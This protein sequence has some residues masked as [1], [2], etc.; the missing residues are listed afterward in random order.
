MKFKLHELQQ[1]TVLLQ[2]V[3]PQKV[4][5]LCIK[6]LSKEEVLTHSDIQFISKKNNLKPE[7]IS[8]IYD[9]LVWIWGLNHKFNIDFYISKLEKIPPEFWCVGVTEDDQG[10]K[11]VL[12]HLGLKIGQS[13]KDNEEVKFFV[14]L[15][16]V[17]TISILYVNDGALYKDFGSGPKARI[18]S[19][20]N[21][22]KK[23][24]KVIFSLNQDFPENSNN[25]S[26][27]R[28]NFNN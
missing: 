4:K 16:K 3:I 22:Y 8:D 18:M 27:V 2:E 10:R 12:G 5:N 20:L 11:N 19:F 15:T 21:S 26:S 1:R 25:W 23:E 13:I 24:L 9:S 7:L 28:S 17:K 6:G 14:N